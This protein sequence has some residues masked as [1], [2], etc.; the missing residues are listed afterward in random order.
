MGF[1]VMRTNLAETL[2]TAQ[3]LRRRNP[4]LHITFG[5]H[6]ATHGYREILTSCP[7]VD[8]VVLGEGEH[9]LL[10]LSRS[11][12]KAQDWR[13]LPGIARA[14]GS[15]SVVSN[16]PRTSIGDLDSLPFPDRGLYSSYLHRRREAVI[17][18]SR[19]CCGTCSFC[20]IHSFY[21]L[22]GGRRWRARSARH[23]V[24]EIAALVDRYGVN[25]IDFVDDDFV[26]PGQRGRS[27][28]FEIGSEILSR[29]I[30]VSYSIL[31]RPD[32]I[33]GELLRH[34]KMSGLYR[35][36]IGIESWIPR[37]LALYCKHTTPERNWRAIRALEDVGLDYTIYLIPFDPY[38]TAGEL[39]AT[40]KM[41]RRVGLEHIP[42]SSLC[43]RLRVTQDSCLHMT[44]ARDESLNWVR[45]QGLERRI[46]YGFRHQE[47]AITFSYAERIRDLYTGYIGPLF[48]SIAGDEL[49]PVRRF[50]LSVDVAIR[51]LVI[52]GC[53]AGLRQLS[54][55]S[56]SAGVES[57]GRLLEGLESD[58]QTLT[59]EFQKARQGE[60]QEIA[61]AIGSHALRFHGSTAAIL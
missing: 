13:Q 20:G 42:V 15:G 29:G 27:R 47:G 6:E 24:D 22:H 18:S 2:R 61:V 52:E 16:A 7:A 43:N 57:F 17:Y 25:S 35:V 32:N 4:D 48:D 53:E 31:C 38:L 49:L 30:G 41:C 21:G 23:V 44:L 36:D 39:L 12:S 33:D 10:E 14:D 9:T 3:Q 51:H 8:S 19:G 58:L 55:G 34:L 60:Y 54:A 28:A 46:L 26:G 37:Q 59:Q 40:Y 56:I 50:L 11:L 5:G 1:S 45:P